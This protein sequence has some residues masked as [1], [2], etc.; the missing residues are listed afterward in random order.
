MGKFRG[1]Q[2]G[3]GEIT[4]NHLK[5][6][7]LLNNMLVQNSAGSAASLAGSTALYV[8]D[9]KSFTVN[10][11]LSISGNEAVGSYNLENLLDKT[12]GGTISANVTFSGAIL[13]TNSNINVTSGG[14]MYLPSPIVPN[15]TVAAATKGYVDSVAVGLELKHSCRVASTGANLAL[16]GLQ[17]ID[18]IAIN[19]ND[20]VLVKDQTN[21]VNNGIYVASTG[22]WSRASDADGTNGNVSY[23]MFTFIETGSINAGSG[24][25]L[26]GS[27]VV[28]VGTTPLNFSQFSGA[29]EITAGS[30]IVKSGNTLSLNNSL[31]GGLSVTGAASSLS[32]VSGATLSTDSSVTTNF[33]GP[34]N[35]NGS[36]VANSTTTFNANV[37]M[38]NVA[39]VTA[40]SKTLD[41]LSG[42]TLTADTGSTTNINGTL[43]VAGVSN[44]TGNVTL[45]NSSTLT[46]NGPVSINGATVLSGTNTLNGTTAVNANMTVASG[47]TLTTNA[48]SSAIFNGSATFNGA[49][50]LNGIVTDSGTTTFR[51]PVTFAS[52][53]AINTDPNAPVTISGSMILA[54]GASMVTNASA[55]A[56]FN[57]SVTLAG[58]NTIN[59]NV[60]INSAVTHSSGSSLVMNAGAPSTFN[61]SVTLAGNTQ[62]NGPVTFSGGATVASGSSLS[63]TD[64]TNTVVKAD[65]IQALHGAAGFAG[66]TTANLNTLTAGPASDASALHKH[67]LKSL[68]VKI[69]TNQYKVAT[70][71]NDNVA[72]DT[73]NY[74]ISTLNLSTD[75]DVFLN[76]Q[77]IPSGSTIGTW[78]WN[79]SS[80]S[81]TF[82]GSL[83]GD[84]LYVRY[85]AVTN[86]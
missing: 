70:V 18:G 28:T 1:F 58:A 33:A 42:A 38:T 35:L 40:S 44:F 34:V 7:T 47:V 53:S 59:G 68:G 8:A 55:P 85:F 17:T 72:L 25:V 69:A 48:G 29:G 66:I 16:S 75:I 57:G 4:T 74:N 77:W 62:A 2:I 43:N 37:V 15:S 45:A 22:A 6:G 63:I 86:N 71:Q 13:N 60:T 64:G 10:N 19:A 24:W 31:T 52:G 81:V 83:S 12:R 49:F 9:G 36:A 84:Q 65:M 51:T 27:G 30:N 14:W 50:S 11:T 73:V 23:G 76:G 82:T 61:G 26:I 80:S 46:A 5:F 67:S 79:P 54:P 41:I 20:R 21:A 56:T 78:T 32:I 39:Q 3:D